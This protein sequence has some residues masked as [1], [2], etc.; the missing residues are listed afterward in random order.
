MITQAY[1]HNIQDVLINEIRQAQKSIYVAVA[2]L[3]DRVILHELSLK[4]KTG[5]DVQLMMVNDDINSIS[6]N[7][8]I[9]QI[10]GYGGKVFLINPDLDGSIMHHKFCVI[11]F[12]TVITGSYNWSK[13]AQNNHENV[14]VTHQA[15]ELS[16]KF[17]AEF[18]AIRSRF[19]N[20]DSPSIEMEMIRK[21]LVIIKNLIEIE[22]HGEIFIHLKKLKASY[23]GFGISHIIESVE[24]NDYDEA[25]SLIEEYVNRQLVIFD[26]P[27]IFALKLELKSLELQLNALENEKF[28]IERVINEFSILY[29]NTL[30]PTIIEILG[31][32]KRLAVTKDEQKYAKQIEDDF[33]EDYAVKMQKGVYELTEEELK[34]LKKAYREASMQCH[35]DKFAGDEKKMEF[36]EKVFVSLNEAYKSNDLMK[37]KSILN[38]LNAGIIQIDLV[39]SETKAEIIRSQIQVNKRRIEQVMSE[40][41][42]L[43]LSET[44]KIIDRNND[45]ISYL[46]DL[47]V[48]LDYE[49]EMLKF[50]INNRFSNGK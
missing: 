9:D 50:E 35:P 23:L 6:T 40:I 31:L 43:R 10:T 45:V 7:N 2:W 37:V 16:E 41:S 26:D 44:F 47:K 1:F 46:D 30:G 28:E 25:I 20:E 5:L 13:R 4:A 29:N 12:S 17:T 11:D 21:R 34:E 3:T 24:Q 19:L 8:I 32:K 42:E 18:H 27:D 14:I 48:R 33:K 38:E 49:L 39:I 15:T 36:A 22:E